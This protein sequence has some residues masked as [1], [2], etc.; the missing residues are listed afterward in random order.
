M[1]L[2]SERKE[3]QTSV[4]IRET[5]SSVAR[6]HTAI[7]SLVPLVC[8]MRR[9]FGNIQ[10]PLSSYIDCHGG[11]FTGKLLTAEEHGQEFFKET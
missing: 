9:D 11:G 3:F 8:K 4:G 2:K 7:Q 6:G 1:K 10:G 5:P